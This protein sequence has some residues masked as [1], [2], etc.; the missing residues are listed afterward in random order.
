MAENKKKRYISKLKSKYRLSIYNDQTFEEV[1]VMRLSRLNVIALFG[2]T[3]LFIIAMVTILIAFTPIREFIPGYPDGNTRRTI[4][5]NALR[6]DSLERQIAQWDIYLKHLKVVINGGELQ[7]FG[8]VKD[9]VARNKD[10]KFTRSAEDSLLRAQIEEEELYN[11]SVFEDKRGGGSDFSSKLFIA[12]VKG[13]VTNSFDEKQGHFGTDLV[14]SPN[15]V[16]VAVADGVVTLSSWT[17]DTGFVI[18]LQHDGNL[19]S[20][21]KHNSKLLKKQGAR[22][23]AGEAIAIIGNSGELSTGPHL[24]FEMWYN[25]TPVNSEKY[26]VF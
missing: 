2:G 20:V 22:V 25:G 7:Q 8:E 23:K 4:V 19:L 17:L 1:W 15:E 11:L 5:H 10:I 12:P 6:A 16:V 26:I 14:A 18:Q 9:T 13:V 24:H 3:A 21:Y